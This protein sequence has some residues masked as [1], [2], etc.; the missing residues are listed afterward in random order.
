MLTFSVNI[1]QINYE[2]LKYKSS[3][4]TW[5][6]IFIT[7]FYKDKDKVDVIAIPVSGF[8]GLKKSY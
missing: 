4:T 6:N 8:D 2:S 3:F 7:P 5:R 1:K